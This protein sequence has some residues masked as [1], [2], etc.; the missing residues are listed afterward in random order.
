MP[1]FGFILLLSTIALGGDYNDG[2]IINVQGKT[3]YVLAVR[4]SGDLIVGKDDG[5]GNVSDID[6]INAGDYPKLSSA[7]RKELQV[8]AYRDGDEL[9]VQGESVTV[10]GVRANGALIIRAHRNHVIKIIPPGDYTKIAHPH[11]PELLVLTASGIEKAEAAAGETTRSYDLKFIERTIQYE[12]SNGQIVTSGAAYGNT[13]P[14]PGFTPLVLNPEDYV[15]ATPEGNRALPIRYVKLL[16]SIMST[17]DE[18]GIENAELAIRAQC[19]NGSILVRLPN[20]GRQ[21]RVSRGSF[22]VVKLVR[23]RWVDPTMTMQCE[24][25]RVRDDEPD[26]LMGCAQALVNEVR[27]FVPED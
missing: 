17:L 10:L 20:S 23:V 22:H 3:I 13:S 19:A 11:K 27:Q 25:Y 24:V 1:Y 21:V 14:G 7:E 9:F 4:S 16:P 26:L 12:L 18:P 2:D 5:A 6:V 8:S 15:V